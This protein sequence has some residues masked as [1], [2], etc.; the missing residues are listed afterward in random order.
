MRQVIWKEVEDYEEELD[1]EKIPEALGLNN[2]FK[3]QWEDS[4][5]REQEMLSKIEKEKQEI[6]QQK[7]KIAE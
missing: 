7:W 6:E 1:E 3:K 4:L 2:F 5:K